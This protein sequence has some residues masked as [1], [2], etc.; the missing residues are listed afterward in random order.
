MMTSLSTGG[1][2]GGSI[3][4]GLR[5]MEGE[6]RRERGEERR[7]AATCHG[8]TRLLCHDM[9]KSGQGHLIRIGYIPRLFGPVTLISYLFGIDHFY[10]ERGAQ[11]SSFVLRRGVESDPSLLRATPQFNNLPIAYPSLSPPLNR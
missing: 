7:P 9:L 2:G 11:I 5:D 3:V 4:A 8:G 6:R 1:G 10:T